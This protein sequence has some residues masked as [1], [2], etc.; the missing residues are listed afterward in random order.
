[1]GPAVAQSLTLPPFPLVTDADAVTG[2]LDIPTDRLDA[3]GRQYGEEAAGVNGGV[4]EEDE[5]EDEDYDDRVPRRQRRKQQQR[6]RERGPLRR[7]NDP[8]Q[9]VAPY[10]GIGTVAAPV[11]SCN[12]Q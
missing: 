1:M 5:D 6:Q 11:D 3:Q 10:Q 9:E 8:T 12:E 2:T 7:M 4:E